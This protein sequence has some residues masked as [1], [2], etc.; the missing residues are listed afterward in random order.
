MPGEAIIENGLKTFHGSSR[1]MLQIFH[2][3]QR[4]AAEKILWLHGPIGGPTVL[5]RDFTRDRIVKQLHQGTFAGT[6][7]AMQKQ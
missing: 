7:R 1:Q 2:G 4:G 3:Q 5:A 6:R